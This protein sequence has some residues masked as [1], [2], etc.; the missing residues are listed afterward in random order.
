M[1]KCL[2]SLIE[3]ANKILGFEIVKSGEFY[4]LSKKRVTYAEDLLYT[5]NNADFI[6]EK[7][8][9]ESYKL[10]R[11]TDKGRLLKDYD[12]RWRIHVLCWAAKH[13]SNLDG[14]FV[15]CGTGTGIFARAIINYI[16]FNKYNKQ[17]Y[18]LDT[19]SGL[20]PKYSSKYEMKRNEKIGYKKDKDIYERTKKT[21]EGFRVRIIKGSI[22][23]SLQNVNT[24]KV[25]F[26]SIDL[27]SVIPE[28]AALEFFWNKLTKGAIVI[29]DDYGYPGSIMQKKAD[30][31]FA[32]SKG[33]EI[34]TLPTSQGMIIKP[35]K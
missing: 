9:N 7:L 3:K 28:I 1:K 34:L 5:F 26:L 6:N 15:D 18:L 16:D 27:N 25:A 31:K 21:F 23:E 11:K 12:I 8:F 29:L 24:E 14:D 33:V 4:I 19:F 35:Q 32:K 13:A 22:P 20:D 30:D 10:G 2:I 17:Y